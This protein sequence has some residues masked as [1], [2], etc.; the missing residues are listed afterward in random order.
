MIDLDKK[1]YCDLSAWNIAD[2]KKYSFCDGA[3]N[4][5]FTWVGRSSV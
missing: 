3:F 5:A 4:Q 2:D 1:G